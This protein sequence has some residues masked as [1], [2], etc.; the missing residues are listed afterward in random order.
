MAHVYTLGAIHGEPGAEELVDKALD[1]LRGPLHDDVNGGWYPSITADGTPE[2]GKVC[3]THAFVILA[4][5]SATLIGRPGAKELLSEALDTYNAH[6]WD[7][8]HGL[9]VNTSA[10]LATVTDKQEYKDWYATFWRYIDEYLIDH[11]HGSCVP[12]AGQGQPRHR[13]RVARQV[14]PVPR[15]AV[16]VHPASESGRLRGPRP[17]AG[18][19]DPLTRPSLLPKTAGAPVPSRTGAPALSAPKQV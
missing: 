17:E 1:G 9:A 3:Y 19:R 15:A 7:E 10:V 2:A 14:R 12:P 11:E 13:H 5:T 8:E 6:F 18:H 16:H 4:A